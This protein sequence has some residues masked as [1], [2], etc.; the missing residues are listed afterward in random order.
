MTE[1]RGRHAEI[2]GG[3]A[4]IAVRSDRDDGVELDQTGARTLFCFLHHLMQ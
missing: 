3:D 1:R 4:K 2:G